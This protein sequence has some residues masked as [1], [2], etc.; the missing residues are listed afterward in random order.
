MVRKLNMNDTPTEIEKKLDKIYAGKSGEEKLLIALRMFDTARE[1][2]ISSFP[3]NLTAGEIRR[4]LFMR[5][6]KDDFNIKEQL[7]ILSKL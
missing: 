6:Y 1:I 5:F 3:V 7:A 2:V 4:E